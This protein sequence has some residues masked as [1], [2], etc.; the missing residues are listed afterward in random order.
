MLPQS[1]SPHDG[2]R[3]RDTRRVVDIGGVT[4]VELLARL[5]LAGVEL[6]EAARI[7][8]ADAAFTTSP[9][10]ESIAAIE[11]SV[12]DLGLSAGEATFSRILDAARRA[13]LGPCPLETAARLRLM[14][15]DQ[16][17]GPDDVTPRPAGS[18]PG[19][20]IVMTEPLREDH[21]FPKGFYL[22]RIRDTLWLRGYWCD[23]EHPWRADERLLFREQSRATPND[24]RGA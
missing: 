17:E 24:N 18:P 5:S 20:V 16:P 21:S 11:I 1:E 3:P 15:T 12:A 7:L 8:F 4:K 10:C 9:E 23:A 2:A 13:G 6:N 19:A 14:W 22:R